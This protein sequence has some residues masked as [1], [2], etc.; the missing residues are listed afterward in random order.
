V[1]QGSGDVSRGARFAALQGRQPPVGQGHGVQGGG[2]P[3]DGAQNGVR[4]RRAALAESVLKRQQ[5]EQHLQ[6]GLGRAAGVAA[7]GA[8][9]FV[10]RWA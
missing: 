4:Q 9:G 6:P 3:V 7:V 10:E 2:Q 8:D 1:G 5:V